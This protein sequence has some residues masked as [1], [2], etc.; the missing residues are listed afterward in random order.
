MSGTTPG[1]DDA[2]KGLPAE[3]LPRATGPL[4]G[5]V[6]PPPRGNVILKEMLRG[7]SERTRPTAL[8][9]GS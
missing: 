7:G 3:Q 1:A 8:K 6:P 4:M 9:M 5:D 2:T